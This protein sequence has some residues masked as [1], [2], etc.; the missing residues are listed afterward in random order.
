MYLMI[1]GE[2]EKND[3]GDDDDDDSLHDVSPDLSA[4]CT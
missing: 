1:Y 3:V 4:A 2:D